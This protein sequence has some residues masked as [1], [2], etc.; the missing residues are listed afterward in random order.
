[1]ESSE[2]SERE[3][4]HKHLHSYHW[5][6]FFGTRPGTP[7]TP[8]ALLASQGSAVPPEHPTWP[9][10]IYLVSRKSNLKRNKHRQWF[11]D[12]PEG[13]ASTL[14]PILC[15]H[16]ELPLAPHTSSPQSVK[17]HRRRDWGHQSTSLGGPSTS[18]GPIV[19]PSPPKYTQNVTTM[20]KSFTGLPLVQ[21]RRTHFCF[22]LKRCRV[23]MKRLT[24]GQTTD[25]NPS[26]VG[27]RARNTALEAPAGWP[28]RLSAPARL[29]L[30]AL[31]Q[32]AV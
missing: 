27:V 3:E 6:L 22:V 31:Y 29:S 9:G 24:G 25:G 15:A 4:E 2:P 28:P 20:I 26:L 30:P 8:A 21:N 16:A 17:S 12:T 7:R 18:P 11:S 1:M 5:K 19:L 32:E 23:S 13:P 10:A 14:R